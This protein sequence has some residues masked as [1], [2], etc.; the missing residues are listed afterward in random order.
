MDYRMTRKRGAPTVQLHS[1]IAPDAM[2]RLQ[3]V[4]RVCQVPM[5]AVVEAAAMAGTPDQYGIPQEWALPRPQES[6]LIGL[7]DEDDQ[8]EKTA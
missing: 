7:L 8:E 4:A 2:H 3:H 6:T 1:R 5:W